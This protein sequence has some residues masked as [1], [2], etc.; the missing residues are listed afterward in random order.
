MVSDLVG[1]FTDP[2]IVFPGGW[3]DTLPDWLKGAIT[4]DRLEANIRASNGEE[5]T[6][7]DAEACAYL[8]TAGLTAPMDHD[9]SQIYLY[10]ASRTYARHKGGQ[11]PE[12]I[13]VETTSDYQMGELKRLK[14]WLYRQRV[15]VRQERDRTDRKLE[16]EETEAQRKAEQPEL[17]EF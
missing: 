17:F 5:P 4:M 12:D 9:W 15:K 8:Y 3:G 6:G 11:V 14:D 10:V 13:R 7:T 16:R 2:I 1:T